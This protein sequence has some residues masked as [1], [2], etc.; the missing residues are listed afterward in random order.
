MTTYNPRSLL[1]IKISKVSGLLMTDK[2]IEWAGLYIFDG[3]LKLGIYYNGEMSLKEL[4]EVVTRL[5]GPLMQQLLN[6][7]GFSARKVSPRSVRWL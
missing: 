3:V 5:G 7:P 1:A 4:T 6:V 2:R